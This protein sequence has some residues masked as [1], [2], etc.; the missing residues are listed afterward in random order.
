MR[1]GLIVNPYAG[2]GGPFAMKG[3][4]GDLAEQAL[5]GGGTPVAA[6][7]AARALAAVADVAGVD[8]VTVAGAMGES[9][10]HAAGL[11]PTL[12]HRAPARPTA[13]DTGDAARALCAAGVDLLL[14][15]GGDGTA[16]ALLGATG[17]VPVL[18]VPAGVR[19][20]SGVFATSPAAAGAMLRDLVCSR[21]PARQKGA[22]L[23]GNRAGQPIL[24]GH[25]P[26]PASP[27]RQ[28]AKQA[29]S[30]SADPDLAACCIQT[31]HELASCPLAVI[32]T[33]ATMLAV[34]QAL[35]GD[36]TLLGVDVFAHGRLIARDADEATLWRLVSTA[37][38]GAVRLVLGVVGGQGFVLGRGNQQLSPR[39]VAAIPRD[40]ISVLAAAEKLAALDGGRL[41]V[42]TDDEALDQRLAGQISVRIGPRRRM[43]MALEAG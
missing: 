41:L 29:G 4:D 5:A 16:R 17:D 12:V 21:A 37:D 3:T 19:M 43:V 40:H 23:E 18:G 26:V 14:F 6:T 10:A 22:V 8:L 39:V 7:R 20:H 11:T 25:L 32:G 15:A 2:L 34:K 35:G 30:V 1:V 9:A 28:A 24:H 27:R 13:C 38:P 36:G 33:G 42:D 31:A